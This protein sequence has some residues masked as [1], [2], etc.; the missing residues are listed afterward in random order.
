MNSVLWFLGIPHNVVVL[1]PK[2]EGAC[3]MSTLQ[4]T[5]FFEHFQRAAHPTS[6]FGGVVT[7]LEGVQH[8][9]SA[10]DV[11]PALTGFCTALRRCSAWTQTWTWTRGHC[12]GLE[13]GH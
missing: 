5:L 11:C 10:L 7:S 6:S 2:R 8:I 13:I 1:V 9:G 12:H 4:S 3:L